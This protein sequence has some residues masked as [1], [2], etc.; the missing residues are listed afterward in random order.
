MDAEAFLA[1]EEREDDSLISCSLSSEILLPL[2]RSLDDTSNTDRKGA[3]AYL[4]SLKERERAVASLFS[5]DL[6][7][8]RHASVSYIIKVRRGRVGG[9][10]GASHGSS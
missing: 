6:I 8:R 9:C 3:E 10:K 4:Y 1:C 7:S 5:P 2:N